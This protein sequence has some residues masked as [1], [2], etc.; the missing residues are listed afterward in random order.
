MTD[1]ISKFAS[2][3]N[4]KSIDN[5]VKVVTQ[6]L[7]EIVEQVITEAQNDQPILPDDGIYSELAQ[8]SVYS[9][10]AEGLSTN[11]LENV[12]EISKDGANRLFYAYQ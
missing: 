8:V 1:L 6:R 7:A 11:V 2:E 3:A 5:D 10:S 12:E 4:K 9:P